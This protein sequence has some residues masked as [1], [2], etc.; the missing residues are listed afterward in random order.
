[1]KVFTIATAS[2]A[3][4]ATEESGKVAM[5]D[6]NEDLGTLGDWWVLRGR[7]VNPFLYDADGMLDAL[8]NGLRAD[9]WTHCFI[10]GP[11]YEQDL[12]EMSVIVADAVL[13]PIKLAY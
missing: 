1:M 13:I 7:P 5:I 6:L 3:V 12:I 11:P 8:V 2:L 10:D 4:R 9:N